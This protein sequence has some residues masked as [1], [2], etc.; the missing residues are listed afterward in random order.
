VLWV[1]LALVMGEL[2]RSCNISFMQSAQAT[3]TGKFS[4]GGM[5]TVACSTEQGAVAEFKLNV[6][7]QTLKQHRG[8]NLA[9]RK[10]S[11][12]TFLSV[13]SLTGDRSDLW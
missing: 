7:A 8:M 6:D 3:G 1:V 13:G 11:R 2:S 12:W 10:Q 9:P 4:T 5:Q